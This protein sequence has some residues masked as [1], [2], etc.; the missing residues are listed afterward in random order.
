MEEIVN[1]GN[2]RHRAVPWGELARM[3]GLTGKKQVHFHTVR[4]LMQDREYHKCIA[5]T[6]QWLSDNIRLE[7][8]IFARDYIGYSVFDWKKVRW[9]DEIHF[10]LGPEKKLRIIRRPGE[11]FCW[12]CIQERG[13]PPEKKRKKNDKGKGKGKQQS[14]EGLEATDSD[15]DDDEIRIHAWAAVGWNFKTPL[16]WYTTNNKNGKMSQKVYI[17]SILEPHVK[18]WIDRGDQFELEEDRDSGHGPAHNGNKV[19]KY[20]EKIGLRYYFNGP[21]SPDLSVA[22]SYFQPLKQFLSNSG[23]WDEKTLKDRAEE[24]WNHHVPQHFINEQVLS[25]P[26]RLHA[27]L[28]GEGRMTGY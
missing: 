19:R 25:M 10:G 21:K 20:K 13:P 23:H 16:I 2:I 18:E 15:D 26:K 9:S 8:R 14:S 5:C 4:K 22:E 6:K 12:S 28:D 1:D 3:A 17:E 7:R 24:G 11:R 27:C